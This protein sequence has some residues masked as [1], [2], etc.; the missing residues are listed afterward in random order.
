MQH[1]LERPSGLLFHPKRLPSSTWPR[2][3][4]WQ[5]CWRLWLPGRPP[6]ICPILTGR[7][8]KFAFLSPRILASQETLMTASPFSLLRTALFPGSSRAALPSADLRPHPL[9]RGPTSKCRSICHLVLSSVA[10]GTL[11]AWLLLEA[12]LCHWSAS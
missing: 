10:G 7:L 9:T 6:G 3:R 5:G 12:G 2:L 11:R 1:H 8:V 4:G